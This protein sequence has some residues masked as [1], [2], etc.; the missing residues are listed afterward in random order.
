VSA[1]DGD[2]IDILLEIV[3]KYKETTV[4]KDAIKN[5]DAVAIAIV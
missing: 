3:Q 1:K 4:S 5:D 2:N